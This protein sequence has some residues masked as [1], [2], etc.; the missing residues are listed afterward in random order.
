MEH[1]WDD[2]VRVKPR[3][4]V[5]KD[6]PIASLYTTSPSGTAVG[7]NIGLHSKRLVVNLLNHGTTF[8]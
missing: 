7:L 4:W 3:Y 1:W 5:K 6:C 2:T 8:T